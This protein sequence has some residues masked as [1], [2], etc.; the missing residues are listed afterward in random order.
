MSVC[1]NMKVFIC[2]C[3]IFIMSC[4]TLSW[5]QVPVDCCLSVKNK[6]IPGH[7]IVSHR[8]QFS[9]QGCA[10][11][12]TILVTR[13]GRNLCVPAHEPWVKQLIARV[14]QRNSCTKHGVSERRRCKQRINN[15]VKELL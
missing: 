3:I 1:G 4:C 8:R 11:D 10:I 2:C 9:G 14:D 12:A 5:A 6:T 7:M 15:S 13:R